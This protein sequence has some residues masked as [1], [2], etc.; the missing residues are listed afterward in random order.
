MACA[1]VTPNVTG[2]FGAGIDTASDDAYAVINLSVPLP[3][4]NRNQGNIRTARAQITATSAASERTRLDLESRLAG[5]VGRY[6]S[7]RQRY[8]RLQT[9]VL[10]SADETFELSQAAFQAGESNYLQLLTAQRTLIGTELRILEA[11]EQAREA[12]AEIDGLLV[13][14]Q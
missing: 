1:Q 5:A 4:R 10:P 8:Q 9:K 12:A 6:Q 2:Q 3:I 14:I 13:T 7:A 11:L